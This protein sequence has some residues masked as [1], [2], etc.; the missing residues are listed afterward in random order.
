VLPL[1]SR[2]SLP[3]LVVCLNLHNFGRNK[4]LMSIFLKP[5]LSTLATNLCYCLQAFFNGGVSLSYNLN[6]P[7]ASACLINTS[8]PRHQ[9]PQIP[10]SVMLKI[11]YAV[12]QVLISV[13]HT[14]WATVC[15]V[16][17]PN[18]CVRRACSAEQLFERP[19]F[20]GTMPILQACFVPENRSCA[21]SICSHLRN[22]APT[23]S[24]GSIP[25]TKPKALRVLLSTV[26]IT[27]FNWGI[28]VWK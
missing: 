3:F 23:S 18:Y 12:L 1:K 9:R 21:H 8:V 26:I 24:Q 27:K 2:P 11:W 17:E 10:S 6:C 14:G 22:N 7:Q 16:V 4:S 19:Y 28:K 20:R 13:A 5:H 25:D 15:L